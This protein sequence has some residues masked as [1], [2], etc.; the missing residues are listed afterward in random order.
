MKAKDLALMVLPAILWPISFIVLR[1]IFIY[2][3]LV[4]VF[5]LAVLSIYFH[6][7]NIL[8]KKAKRSAW[9]AVAAGVVGAVLLYLVFYFGNTVVSALGAGGLVGNVYAM[10]YGDVAKTK[11]IVLLAL[12]GLF[13]EIYWRGALQGYIRKNSKTF[14]NYPWVVTT[15]Y[16]T[17]VHISA[18]NPIL[19]VAALFV[20]L[21]TSVLA[22]RYGI[23][24]SIAAHIVWIELIV[25]FLP[26]L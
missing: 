10:I 6:R 11:L 4:S 21:V 3:L 13:E 25:V 16:Y 17:L 23:L 19:V 8:W 12:I 2:A 5:I 7:K 14:K 24:S 9:I 15:A 20:G 22:E 1:S 26:V 18:L